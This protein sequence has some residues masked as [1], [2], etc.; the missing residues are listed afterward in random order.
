MMRLQSK[1]FAALGLA[2]AIALGLAAPASAGDERA[3]R[4]GGRSGLQ[5]AIDPATHQIRQ[6][7]AAEERELIAMARAMTKSAGEPDITTFADGTISAILT[8]DYLNVWLAAVDANGSVY[9]VCSDGANAAAA[10]AAPALE[11][12]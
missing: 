5:V 9:Q 10:A 2:A 12:K 6:P 1:V 7:T 11:E 8:A 4:G 3:P